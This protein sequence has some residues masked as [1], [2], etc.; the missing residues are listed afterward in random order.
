MTLSDTQISIPLQAARTLTTYHAT[1]LAPPPPRTSNVDR[2]VSAV[3]RLGLTT[4]KRKTVPSVERRTET[5]PLPQP[6][7]IYLEGALCTAQGSMV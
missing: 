4:L 5:G 7:Q 2:S 1:C 6:F 3:S